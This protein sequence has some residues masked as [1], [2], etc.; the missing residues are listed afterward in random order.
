[1]NLPHGG[2]AR[3][4]RRKIVD[5]LLAIEHPDGGTKARFFGR[6]GFSVENWI[7]LADALILHGRSGQVTAMVP[8]PWGVRYHVEGPL[9]TPRGDSP[10]IR[11]VWMVEKGTISP[12]LITAHPI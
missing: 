8:S 1:M 9:R 3:V 2:H 7:V 10:R 4:E 11:T 6:F 12:R 5:Y